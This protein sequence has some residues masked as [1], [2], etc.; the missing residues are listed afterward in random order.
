MAEKDS[1]RKSRKEKK[2]GLRELLRVPGGERVDLSSY[3]TDS[4]PLGPG[5][6]SA[7]K[8]ATA[9]MGEDLADLQER[10][11]AASRAGDRRRVCSSSRAWTPAARAARS[12]T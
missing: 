4:V 9:R 11:F 12:S 1:R 2:A 8:A 10:L 7:G 5:D 3:D 6:K